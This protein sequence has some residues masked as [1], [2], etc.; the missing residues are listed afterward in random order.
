MKKYL[1]YTFNDTEDHIQTFDELPF[2]SAHFG[3]L[4]FKHLDLEKNIVV[5]DIGSGAGFPLLELAERLGPSSKVYGIDPWINANKRARLKM[6]NYGISNVEIF[7]SSA[8]SI[9]M[10]NNSVDLIISN[11]GLNNFE[12]PGPVFNECRRVLKKG[13]KLALTS[14]LRGHWKEFYTIFYST[15]EQIGKNSLVDKLRADEEHRGTVESISELFTTAGFKINK[16]VTDS[17]E[18]KFADGSAF[19]NHH[20]IKLGWLSTWMNC[21]PKEELD[22]IFTALEINL[23]L[24]SAQMRGLK[25]TVPMVYV[26]GVIN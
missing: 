4:L 18:M 21:F 15:L 14:N 25:L 13:G 9:P 1:T 26:E 23:N 16:C 7:E 2:W 12:K 24:H 5:I 20:F 19:L 22:E 17:F 6:S 11:L 8:V 10:E 3:L